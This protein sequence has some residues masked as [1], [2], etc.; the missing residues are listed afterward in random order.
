MKRIRGGSGLG[1]SL[2]IRPIVDYFI[3]AGERVTA[4]SNYPAVFS[5]SGAVVEPF[6]RTNISVLAHYTQGKNNPATTQWQDICNSAG[7][8]TAL[9]FDWDVANRALVDQL[10]DKAAGRPI[11]VAHGGRAP[12]GRTD[13]FGMELLPERAAFELALSSIPGCF[14][15]GIGARDGA[16]YPLPVELDLI[17]A[18]SVSDLIDIAAMCDGMVAQCSF[19]VPLAECFDKPLLAMWAARGISSAQQYIKT[20]TPS[21]ILSKP[22]STHVMD[23]WPPEQILETVQSFRQQFRPA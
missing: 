13:G 14:L 11:I 23:D 22:T 16:K 4:L 17:G 1:D 5:G 20:I 2:Y 18:T 6:C 19:A 9:R 3:R 7:V 8:A 10:R 21:K 12:M 15:V